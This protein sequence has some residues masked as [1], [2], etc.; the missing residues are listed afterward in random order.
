MARISVPWVN[1]HVDKIAKLANDDEEA[2]ASEDHLYREVL[3]A[4]ADG[5]ASNPRAC[6]EAALKTQELSFSRWY[7]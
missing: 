7:S 4:I 5:T 1:R 3:R 2:H 6:A